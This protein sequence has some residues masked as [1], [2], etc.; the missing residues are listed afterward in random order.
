MVKND[1]KNSRQ[2][3]D[4]MKRQRATGKAEFTSVP[5]TW[6]VRFDLSPTE[7]LTY[8]IIR[9]RTLSYEEKAYT[10]SVKGLCAI[11]NVSIPTVRVALEI[12]EEKGFIYKEKRNRPRSNG[13]RSWVSYVAYTDLTSGSET[14]EEVLSKHAFINST[15]RKKL[16]TK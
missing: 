2:F 4:A 15:V 12:L 13:E 16:N 3:K 10:G 8:C 9:D 6:C 5:L 14:I 11:L 7:L 1:L